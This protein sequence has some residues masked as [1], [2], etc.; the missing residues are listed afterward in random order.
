MIVESVLLIR[1]IAKQDM[2]FRG[3]E[4][5]STLAGRTPLPDVDLFGDFHLRFG[6]DKCVVLYSV[7][8]QSNPM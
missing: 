3:T 2:R 8:I 4:L 5:D 7:W 1:P 6:F